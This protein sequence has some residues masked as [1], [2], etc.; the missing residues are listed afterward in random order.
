MRE[1]IAGNISRYRKDLGLTQEVLADEL[2][3]TFQAVSKWETGQTIPD[4]LLL[5]KLARAL[6]ISVDKLLGYDVPPGDFSY[7][8]ND[9]QKEDYFWGVE[10]VLP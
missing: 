7:Y 5:P 6:N 10:P 4:T 3:I 8:D 9:Y 1:I 2:G